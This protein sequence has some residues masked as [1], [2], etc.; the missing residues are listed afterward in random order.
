MTNVTGEEFLGVVVLLAVAHVPVAIIEAA[1]VGSV[2]EFL[3]KVK[4]E[5]LVGVKE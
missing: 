3:T 5:M 2:A 1:I 4:P